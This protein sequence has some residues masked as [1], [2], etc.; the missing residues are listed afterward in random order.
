MFTKKTI[1]LLLAVAVVSSAAT[2]AVCSRK[3]KSDRYERWAIVETA[4]YGEGGDYVTRLHVVAPD[5]T[6]RI[7]P[8]HYKGFVDSIKGGETVDTGMLA[9]FRYWSEPLSDDH[10]LDQELLAGRTM[11][12]KRVSKCGKWVFYTNGVVFFVKGSSAS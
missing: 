5:G 2:V 4:S 1:G 9:T 3:T 12:N 11:L 10:S 6:W 7:V 8:E